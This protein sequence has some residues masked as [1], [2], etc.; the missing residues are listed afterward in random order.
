MQMESQVTV[1]R[2]KVR[3]PW[4]SAVTSKV[5]LKTNIAVAALD[6]SRSCESRLIFSGHFFKV[7]KDVSKYIV[8]GKLSDEFYKEC[9]TSP[10]SILAV[11]WNLSVFEFVTF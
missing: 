2:D 8:D 1:G 11:A 5:A 3:L 6:K 4:V 10:D 9:L 7:G